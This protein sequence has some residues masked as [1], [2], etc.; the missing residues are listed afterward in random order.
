V[1][2]KSFKIFV[3]IIIFGCFSP[4]GLAGLFWPTAGAAQ[5]AGAVASPPGARPLLLIDGTRL[6]IVPRPAGQPSVI[7][8]PRA[9]FTPMINLNS[10]GR[11]TVIP[12]DALPFVG[13]GLDLSLFDLAA[14][15]QLERGG[16][17]PVRVSYTGRRPVLPGLTITQ[18]GAGIAEGFLTAASARRF[19]AALA[20][21]AAADHDTASYGTDGLFADG[22]SIGLAGVPATR[23]VLPA[24]PMHTLTIHGMNLAGKPDTGGDVTIFNVDNARRFGD[25]M[26]VNQ[27]FSHGVARYSVPAGHYWAFANFFNFA[28]NA[29]RVV[30]LPQFTVAAR[31]A[32]TTVRVDERAASSR[33][34]VSTPRPAA[35]QDLTLDVVRAGRPGTPTTSLTLPIPGSWKTWVSP[36]RKKPTVGSLHAFTQATLTSPPGRGVPYAY[37]LDFVGPDGRVPSQHL[38]AR[39]SSL[40]TVNERYFQD[41]PSTGGWLTWGGTRAEFSGALFFAIDGDPLALPGRQIQY[42]TGSPAVVWSR[43]YWEF[44]SPDGDGFGGQF[45]AAGS[46]RPGRR[47]NEDWNRYPLHPQPFASFAR[48]IDV[49]PEPPSAARA[50]D[51]LLLEEPA[52]GDNS[53]GHVGSGLV[54]DPGAKTTGHWEIDQDGKRLAS[55]GGLAAIPPVRLSARPSMISFTQTSSRVGRH[56]ILS[57]SSTTTWTWRSRRDAATLPAAWACRFGQNFNAKMTRRCAVQPMM[58]LAYHVAGLDLSG[59]TPP[60]AQVIGLNVGHIQLASQPAIGDASMAVSFDDGVTWQPAQV[61]VVKPGRFLAQFT[62]PAG[63]F[64]TLRVTAKDKAGGSIKETIERAY[65]TTS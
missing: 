21:L 24:F 5:A 49:F 7:M 38:V 30:I 17:L 16:R 45:S 48:F 50:G 34:T 51:V 2:R 36:T 65:R 19:G 59:A 43:E 37:S 23:P 40:A 27:V 26:E 9:A 20:R 55:G 12:A 18:S 41:L 8:L 63:S 47:I 44:N 31:H 1:R 56:Y 35:L 11:H 64:V 54:K 22:V 10:A 14:L 62:A 42:L 53:L 58:K 15:R 33:I 46:L 25:P 52:F 39:Q 32:N 28:T 4:S 29:Q 6:T 13:R 57:P 61:S 60:G 3:Y